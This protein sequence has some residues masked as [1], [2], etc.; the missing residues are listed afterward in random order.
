MTEATE[1]TGRNDVERQFQVVRDDIVELSRLLREIGETKAVAQRDA[2]IAE[3]ETVLN[4]SKEILEEG[5][6][7]ARQ[8][9][10]S[11]ED[12]IK[13]KPLQ[14]AA[15]ALGVGFLVGLITRR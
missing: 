4:R 1:G 9:T 15:V 8:S 12:Q 5:R 7:R 11:I 14:A 10:Q 13:E 3:A 6:E 2:A